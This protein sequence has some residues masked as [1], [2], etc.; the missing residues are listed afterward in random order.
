MT[1]MPLVS[2]IMPTYN[3]AEL[4]GRAVHSVL[5]QTFTNL[6]LIV[7]DEKRH[8]MIVSFSTSCQVIFHGQH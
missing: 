1:R 7:V 2:V 3:R 5:N 8:G 4:L 6:E